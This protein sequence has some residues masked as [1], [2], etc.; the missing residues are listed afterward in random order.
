MRT[1]LICCMLLSVGESKERKLA[2]RFEIRCDSTRLGHRQEYLQLRCKIGVS[3]ANSI[4]GITRRGAVTRFR[5][6]KGETIDVDAV[7]QFQ[8][9]GYARDY[10]PLQYRPGSVEPSAAVKLST[11]KRR[12]NSPPQWSDVLAPFSMRL[13]IDRHLHDPDSAGLD[14]IQGYFYVLTAQSLEY[15]DVPLEPIEDWVRLTP[16]LEMRVAKAEYT[17]HRLEYHIEHRGERVI[18]NALIPGSDLPK[19]LPIRTQWLNEDGESFRTYGS[20]DLRVPRG[21]GGITGLFCTPVAKI[22]YTIAI[23]PKHH[24]IPFELEDIPCPS[25]DSEQ[26]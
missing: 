13:Y 2:D 11:M 22:R 8:P 23:N 25:D 5:N 26:R 3:D 19:R 1:I 20:T 24:R 18:T 15:I 21:G 7:E 12:R 17:K 10:R 14:R 16:E 6:T 4:L 9:K